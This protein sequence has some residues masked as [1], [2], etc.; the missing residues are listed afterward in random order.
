MLVSVSVWIFSDVLVEKC[1]AE[2]FRPWIYKFGRQVIVH[3][4]KYVPRVQR[5]RAN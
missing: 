1:R 5:T 2:L 4:V 3:S